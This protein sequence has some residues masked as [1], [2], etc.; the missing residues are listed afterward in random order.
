MM[1]YYDKCKNNNNTEINSVFSIS[2]ATCLV[3]RH[4][5]VKPGAFVFADSIVV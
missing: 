2:V 3:P 4:I 1:V 5:Y